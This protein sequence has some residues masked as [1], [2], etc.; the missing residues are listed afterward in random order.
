MH[1]IRLRGPWQLEPLARYAARADGGLN[2]QTDDLPAAGKA[3]MPIDWSETLGRDFLGVVRYH[4]IFQTPTGLEPH[5]TVW[6]VV[7]PPR[8]Y[9]TGR[10][11]GQGRGGG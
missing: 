8:A 5:E 6:L 7:E 3:T 9:G 10:L 4:R 11:A 2:K 1:T